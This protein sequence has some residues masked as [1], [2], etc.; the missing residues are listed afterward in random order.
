MCGIIGYVGTE[1][2]KPLILDGLKK[3]EY[4]GYDSAGIA[5]GNTSGLHMIKTIGKVDNLIEKANADDEL[6]GTYGIGHTRWATHGTP[7]DVNAHPHMSYDNKF[8]IVHNGI[9][10]N[11]TVLRDELKKKGIEFLSDT[12]T[13]VI[14]Q[15][16]GYY[17]NGDIK[18][19]LIK[20]IQRL[21]GSYAIGVL[22]KDCPDV[23]YTAKLSSPLIIGL[24][25]GENYFASDITALVSHTKNVIDLEDG[26]LAEI[27]PDKVTVFNHSCKEI[28]KDERHVTWDIA[29]A[30][31][32]GYDHFMLKEIFEEPAAIKATID[33]HIKNDEV[34]FEDF[35][36]DVSTFNRVIITACGSAYYAGCV[37]KNIIE[38]LCKIPVETEVA[39]ELRYKDPIMDEKTLVI[40]ISQSGETAD[41]IA[42]IKECKERGAKVMA[43]VNV[44]GSSIAKLADYVVYTWAGPEIAVATTKAYTTQLCILE[45]FA[46]WYA[47]KTDKIEADYYS[48]VLKEIKR[49]PKLAQRTLDLN[50]SVKKLADNYYTQKSVFFIG[51]NLDYSV[52]LEGSLKLK[53]ISYIHSEAYAAGELKH[54]TIALIEPGR[55]VVALCCYEKLLEKTVSNIQ[56]VK[57]RGASVITVATENNRGIVR[58]ADNLLMVPTCDE[59]L[60]PVIEIIPLQLFA[61][62]VAKNNGCDIDK[63]KNLAKSVTVE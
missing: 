57:A 13:E 45:L 6:F 9:I 19:A 48:K 23:V 59:L 52:C 12:D 37:G 36:I 21:E 30:E 50:T 18:K 3:L 42:A 51:R 58:E 44:V 47:K 16:L 60:I 39:S 15:L 22:C 55:L 41:T 1:E 62:Y 29:A 53:E 17:Y 7:S 10:E 26:E 4:R 46:L 25:A 14:V 11:F 8:A 63:P 27:R 61:Y 49:L 54:G 2:A 31:K 28:Q 32:N 5:V 24:G 40:A 35:D 43:I 34:V 38:R 56:Q 20:T 33:T